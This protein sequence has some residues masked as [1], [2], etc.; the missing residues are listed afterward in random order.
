MN[1]YRNKLKYQKKKVGIGEQIQLPIKFLDGGKLKRKHKKKRCAYCGKL[2]KLGR[3][4]LR[5]CSTTCSAMGTRKSKQWGGRASRMYVKEGK[6]YKQIAKILNVPKSQVR[7]LL[8]R[9]GIWRGK[10][11]VEERS[12]NAKG[13]TPTEMVNA[14][15]MGGTMRVKGGIA[16]ES[17]RELNR[18]LNRNK[19]SK[20]ALKYYYENHNESKKKAKDRARLRHKRLKND[21]RYK[22]EK[23]CR[24][25]LWKVVKRAG[26]TKNNRTFDLVGCTLQ[27]LMDHLENQFKQGMAFD[28]YGEWEIDHI[29]PCKLFDLTNQDEQRACFHFTN[30]QPL[31]RGDN[32]R[33][34][35]HYTPPA[36]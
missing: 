11:R 22:I 31:W 32:R 3:G 35:A 36:N 20:S 29:K 24:L 23:A 26:G 28:N 33:K 14:F 10:E 2:K 30:L 19:K 17:F 7:D 21:P 12:A 4:S 5:F 13:L 8:L 16:S 18:E 25:R 27:E 15:G 1:S 6:G 9:K 34:W